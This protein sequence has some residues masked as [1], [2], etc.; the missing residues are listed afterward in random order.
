MKG[1][2]S[3]T[4]N[5]KQFKISSLVPNLAVSGLE[6]KVVSKDAFQE[7]KLLG[8]GGYASVYLGKGKTKKNKKDRNELREKKNKIWKKKAKKREKE[9]KTKK[10]ERKRDRRK[11]GIKIDRF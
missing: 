1:A 2:S 4:L 9:K 5:G 10:T 11:N 7:Q 3:V 8:A 6:S